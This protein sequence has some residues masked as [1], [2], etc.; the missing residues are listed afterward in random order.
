MIKEKSSI[1]FYDVSNI[2]RDKKPTSDGE[3][4]RLSRELEAIKVMLLELKA[5]NA[6]EERSKVRFKQ[7]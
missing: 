6:G 4:K 2:S 3:F 7:E 1:S 5:S